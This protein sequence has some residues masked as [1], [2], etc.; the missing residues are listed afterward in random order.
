MT[1]Q[2]KVSFAVSEDDFK[3]GKELPRSINISEK[4][5]EAYRKILDEAG[6]A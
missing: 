6:I 4:L 5:R 1:K 3:R 2:W